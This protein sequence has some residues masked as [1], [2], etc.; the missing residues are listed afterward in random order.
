M[1]K[2]GEKTK[3]VKTRFAPSPGGY[4]HIGGV[5]T[6]SFNYILLEA[7]GQFLS[8]SKIPCR[9]LERRIRYCNT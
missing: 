4:L 5:R 1:Q 9:T 8:E 7:Q 3:L 2:S 6:V